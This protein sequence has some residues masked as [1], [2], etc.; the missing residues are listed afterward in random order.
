MHF[1]FDYF[2]LLRC[3]S[4]CGIVEKSSLE[5]ASRDHLVQP[6]LESTALD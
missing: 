2:R 1:Y 4:V 6:F 5:G 3:I